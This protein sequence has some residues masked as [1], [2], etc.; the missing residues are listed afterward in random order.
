MIGCFANRCFTYCTDDTACASD[1]NGTSCVANRC[2]TCED[3]TDGEYVVTGTDENIMC[4]TGN[5]KMDADTVSMP[6]LLK[7]GNLLFNNSGSQTAPR[8]LSIN[9]PELRE[10]GAIQIYYKDGMNELS[11]PKLRSIDD[12]ISTSESV[13]RCDALFYGDADVVLTSFSM[14]QLAS[15][16]C[17]LKLESVVAD[18]YDFSALA[19]ILGDIT[20]TNAKGAIQ[21]PALAGS[22][23]GTLKVE[24]TALLQSIDIPN[25]EL[26][27]EISIK[28]N[29]ALETISMARL[30]NIGFMEIS[31]NPVLTSIQFPMLEEF[32][33][34]SM[35]SIDHNAELPCMS[36]CA[37]KDV[38][39]EEDGT[40]TLSTVGEDLFPGNKSDAACPDASNPD[41]NYMVWTA[42]PASE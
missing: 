24:G 16:T 23:L 8:M 17:N 34:G 32:G 11:F 6:N 33:E 20:I 10:V 3:G 12:G 29:A 18:S 30:A 39:Y 27:K 5:L 19:E 1:A 38:I 22:Y 37:F 14:P 15:I 4:T 21:F 35:V 26:I 28:N 36:L 41:T 9:V 13:V 42:C 7:V 25:L 31:Q 40:E 2:V